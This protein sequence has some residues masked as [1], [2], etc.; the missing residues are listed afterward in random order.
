MNIALLKLMK[1]GNPFIYFI[2]LIS[3]FLANPSFSGDDKQISP[4]ERPLQEK[5]LAEAFKKMDK[6]LHPSFFDSA[7]FE[8]L[9]ESVMVV[10][11][12]AAVITGLRLAPDGIWL[13]IDEGITRQALLKTIGG[14]G[15]IGS[16]L[17]FLRIVFHPNT[18]EGDTFTFDENFCFQLT[19]TNKD[20]YALSLSNENLI[21]EEN[22]LNS[23]IILIK[24][25]SFKTQDR[26]LEEPIKLLQAKQM[27]LHEY[28]LNLTED[29]INKHIE[30]AQSAHQRIQEIDTLKSTVQ[31]LG[32]NCN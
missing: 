5:D 30:D 18:A 6:E 1:L 19:E 21:L 26:N 25:K 27:H 29:K 9:R 32:N 4:F 20:L 24:M 7:F 22:F 2:V 12:G 14:I 13:L 31:S 17:I 10:G 3:L 8:G 28:I 15:L 16:G 11:G 23:L